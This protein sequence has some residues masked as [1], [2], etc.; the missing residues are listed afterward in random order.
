MKCTC[1]NE[2]VVGANLAEAAFVEVPV[3]YQAT[4]LV[5]DDEREDRPA[6]VSMCGPLRENPEPETNIVY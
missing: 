6:Q 3:V 5:D 4:S 2:V 1:E